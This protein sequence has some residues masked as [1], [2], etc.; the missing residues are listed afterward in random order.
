M[1]V[2]PFPSRTRQLSSSVPKILG[3]QPPGKIGRRRHFFFYASIAQSVE[4]AAVNRGVTGSSPVWGAKK[5][6]IPFGMLSFFTLSYL[7]SN[8]RAGALRK[9]SCGLFLATGAAAAA[10]CGF[11]KRKHVEP[12]LG[13]YE[14]PPGKWSTQLQGNECRGIL[15]KLILSIN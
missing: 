13:R 1:R 7:G 6:S 12:C 11:A 8:P 5:E 14:S 9:Q 4:H 3:G 2:H 10:R 15:R